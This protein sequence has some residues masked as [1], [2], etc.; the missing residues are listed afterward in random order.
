MKIIHQC[1]VKIQS[2]HPNICRPVECFFDLTHSYSIF[3]KNFIADKCW[4]WALFNQ[5]FVINDQ[6]RI[7]TLSDV[8]HGFAKYTIIHQLEKVFLKWVPS[9][10]SCVLLWWTRNLTKARTESKLFF[11]SWHSSTRSII[12]FIIHKQRAV[13][14]KRKLERSIQQ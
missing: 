2:T 5:S 7:Y 4:F 11:R 6:F 13:H 1:L 9:F 14:N 8:F 10:S 12:R 3:V